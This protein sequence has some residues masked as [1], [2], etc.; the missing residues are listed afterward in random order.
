M[1]N[2]KP[3]VLH[4]SFLP[5]WSTIISLV[6][7][8]NCYIHAA[9]SANVGLQSLSNQVGGTSI[10]IDG[11]RE[12]WE[13][14]IPFNND[15][16][17]DKAEA[18]HID[19]E[20]ITIAH[21]CDDIHIRFKVFDG[22]AFVPDGYRYNLLVDVDKDSLTGFRGNGHSFSI[23]ADILIQGGQDKFSVFKFM[24]DSFQEAWSWQHV[25]FYPVNDQI[26]VDGR[27]DIE[28][29]IKISDLNVFGH[30]I[31]SFN[32]VAWADHSTAIK[33]VYPDNGSLG[34]AGDFNT[35]TLSYRPMPGA[36]ANPE[37]G[38][39]A[40]AKTKP[41]HYTPLDLSTLQCYIKNEGISLV[42]R[43]FYLENFVNSDITQQYLDLMQADFNIL[44]QAGLKVI[45]R[46]S[47][48][49][50]S[51]PNLTPPY[52]DA[53]KDRILAHLHQ[54]SGLLNKNS[55]VIAVMEAGF[56]G[57][58]GEW[59]YSDHF[60]PDSDW[61]QRAEVVFGMLDVLPSNR[62]IQLRTPRSK[63]N[64]FSDA[65]PVD[66]VAAHTGTHLARTGHHNDCFVSSKSDGG[67]FVS[68][69]EYTYLAEETKWLPMSGETC[70]YNSLSD[71]DPNRLSCATALTELAKFHWSF[72]NQDWF[73]PLLRKWVDNGCYAE[74]EK[75]LGYYL[76][77]LSSNFDSQIKPGEQFKFN[78]Q[79]KNEGFAAPFNPRLVELILR[80]TN[81]SLHTFKLQ[82]DP[83]F[84]LP[85]QIH[86]VT[87]DLHIPENLP[88]G[89]YEL[90]LNLPDP[91]TELYRRPEYSIRLANPDVWET[92]TGYNKLN[93]TFIIEPTAIY[94][95]KI[96]ITVG[97]YDTGTLASLKSNDADTY[98]IK[99]GNGSGGKVTDWN[100]SA[101]ISAV[102]PEKIS[103]LNIV[104]SGQ[105]SKKNVKQEIYLYNFKK[106]KWD[107]MDSRSVGNTNDIVV[108]VNPPSPQSY[109]SSD[110]KSR[111]RIR[112]FKS[113]TEQFYSW[114]NDLSWKVK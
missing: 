74:I 39:F 65:S 34:D 76:T 37:R 19:W 66:N 9:N 5:K 38:F 63:Q 70:D 73:K 62:M 67:T 15:P 29:S 59:W 81:G 55:D 33:D 89:N 97:K 91:E 86:T 103:E 22:P 41:S 71:P 114:A 58:W 69:S 95:D 84:W 56:I 43:Y 44:R 3:A 25:N 92:S 80:H 54:L 8:G 60:Q 72:L 30:G 23:G 96:G 68:P 2:N 13:Q 24:G 94:A 108:Q 20:N 26:G 105:Y 113:G 21:D 4:F 111:I 49:E 88:A 107:L 16:A 79:L 64:I 98:D 110:G 46:F 42:H 27:R 50:T 82:A 1:S 83:R 61:N 6:F 100:A 101:T 10:V 28:F 104:Y 52:G 32:W 17:G 77:L 7:A 45:P 40:S 11:N 85:G 53:S 112:G 14:A 36:M 35:Y 109:F 93:R 12:G 99:A 102:P 90:L 47:Y 75:R 31:T 48:S 51:G 78:L 18:D 106:A 87:G 57:L